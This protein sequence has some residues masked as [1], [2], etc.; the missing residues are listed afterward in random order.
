MN[1][2][3][4]MSIVN[5]TALYA[6]N[7]YCLVTRP[8]IV[9]HADMLAILEGFILN[10]PSELRWDHIREAIEVVSPEMIH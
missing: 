1:Y 8:D 10:Q 5:E 2:Y 3:A 4:P 9:E 7:E 6:I